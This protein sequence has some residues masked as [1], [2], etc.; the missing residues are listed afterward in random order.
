M[1]VK[2]L[3]ALPYLALSVLYCVDAWQTPPGRRK[4]RLKPL[5]MP[6]LLIFL[7][8]GSLVPAPLIAIGLF[9]GF[10]GDVFLL[11][12]D[13]RALTLGLSSFL[14]GHGFYVV[15]LFGAGAWQNIAPLPVA[16]YA[17]FLLGVIFLFLRVVWRGAGKLQAAVLLYA[18]VLA[19]L[20]L[21]AMTRLLAFPSPSALS[22][23]FGSVLFI[24]SDGI[25]ALGLFAKPLKKQDFILMLLY[26]LAQGSIALSAVLPIGGF[27]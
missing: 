14:L 21:T 20:S 25:L 16:L 6:A 27:P 24:A 7:L 26:L 22:F 17:V 12:S 13:E 1:V 23:F 8:I 19:F 9:L 2:Y 5:L 11:K 4:A 3:S 10:C 15:S 18:L